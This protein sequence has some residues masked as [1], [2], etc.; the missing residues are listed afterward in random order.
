[1][2]DQTADEILD[3]CPG[4]WS[5][6]LRQLRVRIDMTGATTAVAT[7][8][9][10]EV[11]QSDNCSSSN[12]VI[13]TGHTEVSTDVGSMSMKPEDVAQADVLTSSPTSFP[14]PPSPPASPLPLPSP[15]ASTALPMPADSD[16]KAKAD[17]NA[18][19]KADSEIGAKVDRKEDVKA[20]AAGAQADREVAGTEGK[21]DRKVRAGKQRA[22]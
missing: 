7:A 20:D 1:M 16:A 10:A 22:L 2:Q 8:R 4:K 19:A 5:D 9:S 11:R 3:L 6:V 17:D 14:R 13:G 12:S 21:A 18:E 15:L